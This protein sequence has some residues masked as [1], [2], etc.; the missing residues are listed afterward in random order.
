[1][2][3]ESAVTIPERRW[4]E[5]ALQARPVRLRERRIGRENLSEESI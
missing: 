3:V 1:M 4:A 2:K 5:E